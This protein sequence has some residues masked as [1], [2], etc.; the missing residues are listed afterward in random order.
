MA[1][2]LPSFR[3]VEYG[4]QKGPLSQGRALGMLF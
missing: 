1:G 4:R 2:T 3:L